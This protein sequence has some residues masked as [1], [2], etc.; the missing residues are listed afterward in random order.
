MSCFL[1]SS[2]VVGRF[3]RHTIDLEQIAT[4]SLSARSLQH[5]RRAGLLARPISRFHPVAHNGTAAMESIRT[6]RLDDLFVPFE[7]SSVR[8][9]STIST[10]LGNA[11]SEMT[12]AWCGPKSL[13]STTISRNQFLPRS[14]GS[15]EELQRSFEP[16]T[17]LRNQS[18]MVDGNI[19]PAMSQN[20]FGTD[21]SGTGEGR[22][23]SSAARPP[24][25]PRNQESVGLDLTS[26]KTHAVQDGRSYAQSVAVG[27]ALFQ[28]IKS[29]VS[30]RRTG[31]GELSST[32]LPKD[33][34]T[35]KQ[36]SS[37]STGTHRSPKPQKREPWQVQKFALVEKFGS[38][39]WS[40]RKRLSPDALEGIRALHSQFP[41]KFTTP[42]LAD[43]FKVS[44]E[45]I[46]RILRSKWRP[47][48]AEETSRLKRWDKRGELIWGQMVELG[49][50]PPKRWREMGITKK[51]DGGFLQRES[52]SKGRRGTAARSSAGT[53]QLKGHEAGRTADPAMILRED[54]W[55]SLAERIL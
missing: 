9:D 53:K 23:S 25:S 39:G 10:T 36:R 16:D 22:I 51:E 45:A 17:E 50:K 27:K 11:T 47:N 44:P 18:C 5:H 3:F 31:R 13:Q 8:D 43:Q 46:R 29:Q 12:L 15:G 41:A 2:S 49:I 19:K 54:N 37:T 1:H 20:I 38:Q 55:E 30:S 24:P 34:H 14:Q 7:K 42:V 52:S 4:N 28:G 35:S 6:E 48:E 32:I 21:E 26:S 40:P 33:S